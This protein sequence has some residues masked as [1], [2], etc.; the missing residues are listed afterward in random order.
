MGRQRVARAAGLRVGDVA[1]QQLFVGAAAAQ[2]VQQQVHHGRG[3]QRQ[4]LARDQAADDGDAQRLAQLGAFA[5]T[6]GQRQGAELRRPLGISIIGGLIASQVI[7]LI[8]TP[9][10]YLL[11]DKLRRRSPD[12][13]LLSRHVSEADSGEALPPHAASAA[14]G[15]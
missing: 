15:K 14:T 8:T 12:E 1:A 10:V 7:T 5:E 2:L 9:V 6:D 3:Q 4:Q 13:K 11:L